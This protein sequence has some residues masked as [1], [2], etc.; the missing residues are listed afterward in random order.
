MIVSRENES[1]SL[2]EVILAVDADRVSVA[3]ENE[4]ESLLESR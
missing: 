3:L 4:S 1:E 2:R